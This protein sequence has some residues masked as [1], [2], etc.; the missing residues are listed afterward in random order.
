MRMSSP[1][2]PHAL[3]V[4]GSLQPGGPNEHILASLGGEWSDGFVLGRLEEDGWG[5]KVGYPGIRLLPD[6]DR[7]PV[8]ILTSPKLLEFLRELDEFEGAEYV[9]TLCKVEKGDELVAAFIY[10]LAEQ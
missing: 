10:Q 3:A 7:I 8:K 2:E 5:A 6:G 1:C 9:R 4:Y